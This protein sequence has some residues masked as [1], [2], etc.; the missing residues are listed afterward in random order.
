MALQSHDMHAIWA[1]SRA[2]ELAELAGIDRD[3]LETVLRTTLDVLADDPFA[4]TEAG[5]DQ[6]K[7]H[8]RADGQRPDVYRHHHGEGLGARADV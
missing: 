2:L 4:A 7:V 3:G 8:N 1:N 6:Q 5:A